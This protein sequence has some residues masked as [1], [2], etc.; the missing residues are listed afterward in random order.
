[1]WTHIC[2]Q[3]IGKNDCVFEAIVL[4]NPGTGIIYTYLTG[5]LP[6]TSIRGMQY[7][8]ILYTYDTN[9]ILV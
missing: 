2:Y 9:E 1:M 5:N 4:E 6:V 8:L 3:N 7:T